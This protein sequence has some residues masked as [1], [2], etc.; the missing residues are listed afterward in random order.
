MKDIQPLQDY[1]LVQITIPD[2][3]VVTST[4]VSDT[5]QYGQVLAVGEGIYSY[6]V[7]IKPEVKVGDMVYW[8]AYSEGTNVPIVFRNVD[9]ALIRASRIM[10]KETN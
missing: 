6:G 1:V 9:Q 7:F 10:A 3:G 4:D 5:K 8:E 2:T